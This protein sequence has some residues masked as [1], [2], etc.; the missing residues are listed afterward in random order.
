MK[1]LAGKIAQEA[2]KNSLMKGYASPFYQK[3][4]EAKRR[5]PMMGKSDD[6]TVVAAQIAYEK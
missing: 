1:K 6:I 4:L 5:F 3:A 2:Y